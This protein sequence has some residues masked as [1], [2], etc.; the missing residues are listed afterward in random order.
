M[1]KVKT[2]SAWPFATVCRTAESTT[3]AI[4]HATTSTLKPLDRLYDTFLHGIHLT[5]YDAFIYH[6]FAPPQLRR[7]IAMLGLLHKVTLRKCHHDFH[8]ACVNTQADQIRW[9]C[10]PCAVNAARCSQCQV[11]QPVE[12]TIKCAAPGCARSSWRSSVYT[13]AE[14]APLVKRQA[15]SSFAMR[16][17]VAGS[18]R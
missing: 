15:A 3:S 13:A 11:Y 18:R 9:T 17:G 16:S 5:Q 12:E 7:D 1:P 2:P 8:A 14:S 4:Y 6:N 10:A